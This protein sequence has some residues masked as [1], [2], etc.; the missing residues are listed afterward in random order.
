MRLTGILDNDEIVLASQIENW[1]HIGRLAVDVNGNDGSHRR[2]QLPMNE[3]A[4]FCILCAFAFQVLL[5]LA[6]IHAVGA[7]IDVN[8]V[9]A[10]AGLADRLRGGD[11]S[12]R[13]SDN[14]VAGLDTGSSQGEADRVCS[15]GD[16]HTVRRIAESCKLPLEFLYLG[17]SNESGGSQSAF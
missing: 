17:S 5:E 12:V 2:L 14:D 13:H 7:L 1:V 11:E 3:L 4:G 8:K 10:R 15:A 6:W 9:G 16:T